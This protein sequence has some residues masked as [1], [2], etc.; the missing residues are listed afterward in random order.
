MLLSLCSVP[1]FSLPLWL[2]AVDKSEGSKSVEVQSVWEVYDERLQ[3][4]SRQDALL[5]DESL[6]ADDVSSAWLVWSRLL[7]LHLLML[8]GSVVGPSLPGSIFWQG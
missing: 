5:L 2:P 8:I 6:S 4:M 7:R 3:F 1:P